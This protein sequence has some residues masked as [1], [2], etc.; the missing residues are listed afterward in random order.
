MT[1]KKKK[2]K[3]IGKD[4]EILAYKSRE[5]LS[6]QINSVD[7]NNNKAGIFISISSLF[8][9][10]AFSLIEK[11]QL[12]IEWILIFFLP[13]ILNLIGLFFLVKALFPKFIYNG[14]N[15]KEFDNLI[16]ETDDEIYLMEIAANRDSYLDN[17]LKL[18]KQNQYLK[19]GLSLIFI[20][21]GVLTLITFVNLI[22]TNCN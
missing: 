5:L 20:S 7:T 11:F 9:P 6:D 14:I 16:G 12:S 17:E 22:I 19:T 2:K 1:K 4:S 18:K 15:V 21:V 10:L 3:V 13:I 8:I